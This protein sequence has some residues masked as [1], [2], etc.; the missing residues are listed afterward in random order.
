M[1][2]LANAGKLQASNTEK[3]DRIVNKKKL[4]WLSWNGLRDENQRDFA[5]IQEMRE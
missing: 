4:P 5:T 2:H 3:D 1:E